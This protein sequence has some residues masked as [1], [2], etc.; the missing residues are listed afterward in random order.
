MITLIFGI[1]ISSGVFNFLDAIALRPEVAKDRASYVEIFPFFT[2]DATRPMV[3]SAATL[4]DYLALRD[5]ARSLKELAACGQFQLNFE[6]TDLTTNPAALVSSNFFSLYGLKRAK[7]GRLLQPEDYS[8]SSPV[9]VLSEDFWRAR[10]AANPAIIG[11]TI[12]VNEQLVTVVGVAPRFASGSN[13]GQAWLPYTLTNYLGLGDQWARPGEVRWLALTARLNPGFSRSDAAAELA[14]LIHQ[15]DSLHKGRVSKLVV[16]DGSAIQAPGDNRVAWMV[17]LIMGVLILVL[18]ISCANVTTLLLSRADARQQEMGVR[19]AL[20]ASRTRLIRMLVTETILLAAVA[21]V[22]SLY[23]A[24]RFPFLLWLWIAKTPLDYPVEPDWRVF[25]F[26]AGS[27]LLAGTLAGLAPALESLKVDLL[28]SMKGQRRFFAGRRARGGLRNFLVATQVAISLVLL[29]GSGLFVRAHQQILNADPGYE[30]RQVILTNFSQ[31]SAKTP[32][33]RAN[34]RDN[35]TRQIEALAG[36]RSTALASGLQPNLEWEQLLIQLPGKSSFPVASIQVSANYF[37]TMSIPILRGR[38][39]ERDDAPCEVHTGVC[40]V[41]VSQQFVRGILDGSDV[42][43]KTLRT[44]DGGSLEIVGIAGNVSSQ[45]F[46]QVY[47]PVIYRS[48]SP[49]NLPQQFTLLVRVT[50]NAET[51][52]SNITDVLRKTFPGSKVEARTVRS[53]FYQVA[54]IFWRL[55]MLILLLG[56]MAVL[57]AM[58]GIYGVVSFA[59]SKRTKEIG[60]RIALGAMKKD[61]YASVIGSSMRPI[62]IGLG[63]G[64]PLAIG[65]A[66]VLQ[67]ALKPVA[68]IFSYNDPLSY[69]VPAFLLLAVS[70][71][72]M[73]GPARRAARCDPGRTLREE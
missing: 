4:E 13:F 26:L 28:G 5:K 57:L 30:T 44:P 48:W 41:V 3:L 43:G 67:Q 31:P 25:S 11:K 42:I 34:F 69:A 7:L 72:A 24:C 47:E 63:V 45:L 52:A 38:A 70:V 22:A 27:T 10:F 39:L 17:A 37:A 36:V 23:L 54:G 29:V 19:L 2:M 21:G 32:Q 15:Q 18:I 51:M 1:G 66:R 58:I 20:G 55:E 6:S 40:P 46:T 61:I 53:V 65:G 16:T 71:I 59:V 35:L 49:A 60:I 56:V 68:S 8:K 62:W 73:L 12:H 50:G 14:L 9:V 64:I 33:A